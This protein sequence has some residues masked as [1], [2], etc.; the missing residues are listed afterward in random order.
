MSKGYASTPASSW[1]GGAAWAETA[2]A[3]KAMAGPMAR[4]KADG[5][6]CASDM[7]EWPSGRADDSKD[8]LLQARELAI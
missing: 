5:P 3:R 4:D 7:I 6:K 1:A 8:E 2:D